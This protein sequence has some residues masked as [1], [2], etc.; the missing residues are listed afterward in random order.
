MA[1]KK[2]QRAKK[3]NQSN[4]KKIEKQ[5]FPV[6]KV[7]V[8]A[9]GEKFNVEIQE[10]FK[11]SSVE[12]CIRYISEV[13]HEADNNGVDIDMIS[14][15]LLSIIKNFTDIEFTND[16]LKDLDMFILMTNLGI[17]DQ[18]FDEFNQEELD[19][20]GDKVEKMGEELPK[21]LEMFN[22]LMVSNGDG[23]DGKSGSTVKA[24]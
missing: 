12:G 9:E 14:L 20:L 17:T 1:E 13:Q 3:L 21:A 24:N 18:I 15:G 8:E 16:I 11:P 7:Q 2:Q 4:L 19:K 6:K 5:Q 10:V 23:K 22:N